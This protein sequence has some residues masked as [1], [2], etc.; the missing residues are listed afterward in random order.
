MVWPSSGCSPFVV[1]Y[2]TWWVVDVVGFIKRPTNVAT[3]CWSL[4]L[5]SFLFYKMIRHQIS[6]KFFLKK[7][8]NLPSLSHLV[9]LSFIIHYGWSPTRAVV[10]AL[11][12]GHW[13]DQTNKK[14]V[15]SITG[16]AE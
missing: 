3:A 12:H 8:Y 10:I 15:I 13:Q 6:K 1:L 4:L 11:N 2:I 5:S 7:S 14:H 9:S 16:N